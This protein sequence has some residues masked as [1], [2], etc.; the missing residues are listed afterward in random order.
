V[1]KSRRMILVGN[2]AC[3]GEREGV[4]RVLVCN[5]EGKRPLGSPWHRWDDN[6]QMGLQEVGWEAWTG[7]NW[8]ILRT[9]GRLL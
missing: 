5:P 9:G 6:I 1:I 4:N 2:V 8:F 7:L 3:M